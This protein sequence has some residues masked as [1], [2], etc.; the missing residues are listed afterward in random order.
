MEG[1]TP[2][3]HAAEVV[4]NS[5]DINYTSWDSIFKA[6]LYR[7]S[8]AN[9][10]TVKKIRPMPGARQCIAVSVQSLVE[11]NYKSI[12]AVLSLTGS[13]DAEGWTP[14]ASAA[15][16]TNEALCEFLVEKNCSLCLDTEQKKELNPKLSCRLHTAA[17]HGYKIVLQLRK[18]FSW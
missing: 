11:K 13:R 17:K 12:L 8:R 1:Q 15:F 5:E 4:L 6:F 9:I 2:F 18:G 16:N 14:L 7:A 10:E 3:A